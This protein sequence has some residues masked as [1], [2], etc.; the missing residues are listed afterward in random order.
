MSENNSMEFD[1]SRLSGEQQNQLLFMMLV[2]QHQQIAM[3]GMGKIKNPATDK[4]ERD[5][6]SAKYAIDTLNMLKSY[7]QSNLSKE[8]QDYLKQTISTLQLNYVDEKEKDKKGGAT[9]RSE[10]AGSPEEGK[11]SDEDKTDD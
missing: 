9:E 4:I 2:Q 3:M 11:P 7:T 8:L 5:M 1:A 6:S 10:K